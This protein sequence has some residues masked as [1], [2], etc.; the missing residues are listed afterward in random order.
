MEQR[1]IIVGRNNAPAFSRRWLSDNSFHVRT[2]NPFEATALG[3]GAITHGN[4]CGG[5]IRYPAWA[6][7]V[8]GQCTTVAFARL[9]SQVM[10][11]AH[12]STHH[13]RPHHW[14]FRMQ[15]NPA[16]WRPSEAGDIHRF[17]RA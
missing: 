4:D 14:D 1:S 9:A 5:S 16:A 8:V 11:G 7:G 12:V 15:P 13:G 2:L 17:I 3:M 10:A 6:C